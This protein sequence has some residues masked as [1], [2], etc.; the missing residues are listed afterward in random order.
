MS[1]ITAIERGAR[2]RGLTALV[3]AAGLLQSPALAQGPAACRAPA[4]PAVRETLYF[5][6]SRPGGLV[7]GDDWRRFLKDEVTP[8]FPEGLTVVDGQGQWRGASGAVEQEPSKVLII[9]HPDTAAARR[10]VQAVITAYKRA[11]AQESVLWES[12]KVCA[13]H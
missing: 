2:M 9:D 1:A 13:A 10:A 3:V 5:G 12:E 11:F 7:G 4:A 8:R 6:L